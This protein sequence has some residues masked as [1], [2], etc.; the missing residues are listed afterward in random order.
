MKEIIYA[1]Q[2]ERAKEL[3]T[4]P[5]TI[6]HLEL[7]PDKYRKTIVGNNFLIYDSYE[8]QDFNLKKSSKAEI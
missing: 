5:E 1:I 8:D 6:Q 3:P 4:N 2:R 7:L